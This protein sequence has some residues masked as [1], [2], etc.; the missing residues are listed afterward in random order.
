MHTGIASLISF[1]LAF[2]V[3]LNTLT[4]EFVFD[5]LVAVNCRSILFFV[6]QIK[7]HVDKDQTKSGHGRC[8][9]MKETFKCCVDQSSNHVYTSMV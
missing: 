8:D 7:M 5:D 6:A 1:F 3:Y 2:G 9:C 4:G